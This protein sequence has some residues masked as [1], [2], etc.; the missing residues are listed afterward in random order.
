MADCSSARCQMCML[1][2]PSG[3]A[4]QVSFADMGPDDLHL[5]LVSGAGLLR[6]EEE[7]QQLLLG[8]W[9]EPAMG[10]AL[11]PRTFAN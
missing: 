4:G 7:A 8:S 3:A 11:A 10:S 5:H 1:S 9:P 6:A 2:F